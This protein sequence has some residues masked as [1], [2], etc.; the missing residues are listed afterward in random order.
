MDQ[1]SIS[2]REP[3]PS[4]Q[5]MG[6]C[7]ETINLTCFYDCTLRKWSCINQQGIKTSVHC[8]FIPSNIQKGQLSPAAK[9]PE[10][11]SGLVE[12]AWIWQHPLQP[13]Y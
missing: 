1:H 13:L 6:V 10:V 5:F 12:E 11:V 3:L 2:E 9:L 4:V 8:N 7:V